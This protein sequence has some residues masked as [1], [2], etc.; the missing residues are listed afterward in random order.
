MFGSTVQ[1]WGWRVILFSL[2]CPVL[3]VEKNL[4]LSFEAAYFP[5]TGAPETH[6]SN[7][8]LSALPQ[9]TNTFEEQDVYFTFEGFLRWDQR[10][11]RRNH[12]DIRELK[13][14]KVIDDWEV[15]AGISRIF[16]GVAE[17][18]HLVDIINQTD[19]LEGVDGEDKLGQ[20][21][22]RVSRI[23]EQATLDIFLMPYFREREF[24]GASNRF[25]LP[26][27][28]NTNQ[29]L[30]ESS[31]QEKHVDYAVRFSGYAGQMDFGLSW[32]DGTAR[33]AILLPA[34]S[35]LPELRP[36]YQ[37][38]QR[39]GIDV[40]YTKDAWL[41]KA[42]AINQQSNT[43]D[44]FASVA[45]FE[46]TIYGLNDGAYD[47]GLVLE[48]SSD[49]RDDAS[50]VL[51]QNDLFIATRFS[52]NDAQSSSILAGGFIDMDDQSQV[53]RL[54]ASRRIH[55]NATISFETQVFSHV[56]PNNISFGFKDN[57]F[58]ELEFSWF[59]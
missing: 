38:I 54:E 19:F 51:F 33:E 4:E 43:D 30:Y 27:G 26:L 3:A 16:W 35:V 29:V 41:Y 8:A 22:M 57:D 31:E 52:F 39:A 42:E 37:Q 53:F 18:N 20:P 2:A 6:Q 21:L 34:D 11:N 40:Q 44:Y 7:V 5:Q 25:S 24:L 49:S 10:D 12:I 36:F 46:Y 14:I 48:Y 17:S 58:V 55:D 45:G 28:V 50:T 32:F 9:V 47:L 1:K 23:F 13:G 59:F 15:E 56:G